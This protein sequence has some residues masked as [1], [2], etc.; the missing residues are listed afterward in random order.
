MQ[1]NL[2]DEPRARV[3]IS[4]GQSKGTDEEVT[5]SAVAG[6]LEKLG[7]DPYVAVQEQTLRGL[8]ENIFEQLAKSEYYIFV[9]FKREELRKQLLRFVEDRYFRTKS[10]LLRRTSIF[11]CW[12]SRNW[13]SARRWIIRFLQANAI[14]FTDRSLLP[15][16]IADKVQGR[17][18][19]PHWRTIWCSNVSRSSSATP[20]EWSALL[21]RNLDTSKADFS[22]LMCATDTATK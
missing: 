19:D 16:V 22:T 18:W 17:G 3:F 6:R 14:S 7:F 21:G 15:N 10:L 4:C 12:L 8:K 2:S 11:P 9:D 5:A 1:K 13:E 20:P